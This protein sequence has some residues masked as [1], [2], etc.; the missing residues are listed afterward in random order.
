MWRNGTARPLDCRPLDDFLTVGGP[1]RQHGS[2]AGV[3]L[4]LLWAAGYGDHEG[5]IP[6]I[7]SS[8]DKCMLRAEADPQATKQAIRSE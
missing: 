1:K 4:C 7:F 6:H 8:K 3:V 5:T 2:L